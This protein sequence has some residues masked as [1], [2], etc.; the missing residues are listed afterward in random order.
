MSPY[1][2]PEPPTD[3]EPAFLQIYLMD[4][5]AAD[6]VERRWRITNGL[7]PNIFLDVQETIQ[8]KRLYVREL[9]VAYE[10]TNTTLLTTETPSVKAE[11]QQEPMKELTMH[12][13]LMKLQFQCQISC[14][15]YLYSIELMTHMFNSWKSAYEFAKAQFPSYKIVINEKVRPTGEHKRRY[16][17]L[18]NMM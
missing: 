5:T 11:D 2:P 10:F 7:R 1:R 15:K 3:S 14:T 13:Q 17:A 12:Q 6:H 16:N 4:G 9:Q 18:T 8:A